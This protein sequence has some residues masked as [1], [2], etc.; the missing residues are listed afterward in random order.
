MLVGLVIH[1]GCDRP[2]GRSRDA[3][4]DSEAAS[5]NNTSNGAPTRSTADLDVLAAQKLIDDYRHDEAIPR[6][7]RALDGPLRTISRSIVLTMLG[8]CYAELEQ[9]DKALSYHD[10]ALEAD[11]GNYRAWV[12]KGIVHRLLG[13]YDEA[14][15]C[16]NKAVDIR[17]DYAELHASIGALY[18]WQDRY[19]DAVE[20]LERAVKLDDALAVAHANLALAYAGVGRFAEAELELR[21]ATFRGYRNSDVVQ[22]RIEA[23]RKHAEQPE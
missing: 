21:K 18:C 23:F 13:D 8:N 20:P 4:G 17:P 14:E 6:L 3:T 19:A 9:Y 11:E 22:E 16:Y 12:N 5:N 1:V 2:S 7:E 15:R 10:R